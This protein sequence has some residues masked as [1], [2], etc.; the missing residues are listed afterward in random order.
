M[1]EQALRS[2]A[3][4]FHRIGSALN[5]ERLLDRKGPKIPT[6]LYEAIVAKKLTPDEM[7]KAA[8]DGFEL[9]VRAL[10]EMG[11]TD[12]AIHECGDRDFEEHW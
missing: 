5:A 4:A 11:A 3:D 2:A 12:V 6:Q 9:C 1:A 8:A 7:S 10:A